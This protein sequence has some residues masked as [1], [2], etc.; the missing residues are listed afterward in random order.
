MA[1]VPLASPDPTPRPQTGGHPSRLQFDD[2]LFDLLP[3]AVAILGQDGTVR[4]INAAFVRELGYRP[5]YLVGRSWLDIVQVE[6]RPVLQ[7]ALFAPGALDDHRNE[8]LYGIEHR[9]MDQG[10]IVH[11]VSCAAAAD[12]ESRSW[13]VTLHDV[14][15]RREVTVRMRQALAALAGANE[16]L[17]QFAAAASHDIQEPLRAITNYL[18]LLRDR[19]GA[20]L[21]PEAQLYLYSALDSTDQLRAFIDDLL[22]YARLETADHPRRPVDLALVLEGVAHNLQAAIVERGAQ[23]TWAPLP[24]V[25]GNSAQLLQLFQN[26]VGNAIKYCDVA[27]L[28]HIGCENGADM[29]H[30][31][32]CD[33][34]IGIPVEH[35]KSVFEIF[36]RLHPR[37]EYS[38]T[39]IGLAIC[40]RI[41]QRHGGQIWIESA[42]DAGTI[43]HL[44][45]PLR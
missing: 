23:V 31:S 9:V 27:P 7:L 37:N 36:R 25:V 26:L 1:S 41:V 19:H 28:I 33:N 29:A 44:T 24:T 4:R 10:G 32:V 38:G 42:P 13:L 2:R 30:I 20:T 16:R 34:G 15:R 14:T 43:F 40:E 39:G 5:A 35:Q 45:L 3:N 12:P 11:Q 17:Q 6:D 21:D 18:A 22:Q 8:P